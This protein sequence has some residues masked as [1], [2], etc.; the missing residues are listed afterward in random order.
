MAGQ[1][2]V[3]IV[4]YGLA[5]R[6]FHG[7]LIKAEPGTRVA[8]V[9]TRNPQRHAQA[10]AD[11]PG[12]AVHPG[13]D[14]MLDAGALD[15]V[16]IAAPNDQH[17]PGALACIAAGVPVVVDKPLAADAAQ[18]RV[19]VDQAARAGV[20]LSVFQNRRWDSDVLTL[21]RLLADG[22]LGE[23]V[24]F[25]SRFERWRPTLTPG[26]RSEQVGPGGGILLDLGSHLVD[27]AMHL[28][29]PVRDV[30]GEVAARRGG[31]DDDM[32]CSLEHESGLRSHLSATALAGAP[33]P[34]M[35]VLGTR[36]AYVVEPLDGQEAMLRE[37]RGPEDPAY[38]VEPQERCGRLHRGDEVRPIRSE[39]GRWDLFYAGVA[40]ALT[41]GTSMPVDPWDVVRA[42]DVL[43]RV[44]TAALPAAG[45]SS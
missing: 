42:L 6:I 35:R 26:K 34:R 28:F 32:F 3:G 40:S 30:H 39:R 29:G 8:A 24:R 44:R 33:G 41:D 12:V 18:A 36:G 23:V 9:V 1:L 2:R 38:G 13:L 4:G 14:E 20:P 43:D 7:Q 21:R 5:G 15:L 11:Q 31:A 27:Q 10:T 25:E 19:V 16:V 37:G 45:G 22:E 17:V